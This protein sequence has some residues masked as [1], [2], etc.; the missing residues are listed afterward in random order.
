METF[1]IV[2]AN[3]IIDFCEV[4]LEILSL[5]HTHIGPVCILTTVLSEVEILSEAECAHRGFQVVEPT[6][7]QMQEAA[8]KGGP[9]SRVDWTCLCVCRDLGYHC[10]TNDIAL[11]K[12]CSAQ[13]IQVFWGLELIVSLVRKK[14]LTK[15]EAEHL[16]R[17][18]CTSNPY[19]A[20]KVLSD[21]LQKLD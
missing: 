18:I 11:R 8:T 16:G 5:I 2:D 15:A 1:L 13:E 10:V 17:Q 19:N 21:F 6:L 12:Q 20:P 3:V 9:L 7:V 14:A 4:D